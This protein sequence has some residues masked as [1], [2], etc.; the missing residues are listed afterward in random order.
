M[1]ILELQRDDDIMTNWTIPELH[2]DHIVH[3]ELHNV[4]AVHVHLKGKHD[5]QLLE[6]RIREHHHLHCD[7]I[8]QVFCFFQVEYV[9]DSF[10]ELGCFDIVHMR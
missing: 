2:H 6:R 5:K 10:Y 8:R 7:S 4:G 3:K 1:G 9:C